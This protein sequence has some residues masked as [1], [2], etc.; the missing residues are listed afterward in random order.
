LVAAAIGCGSDSS[1]G[2][3]ETTTKE[4]LYPRIKG[5][6]REF[7][8]PGGDNVT[9]FFGT[10]ATATERENA[11]KVVHVWMK[12]RVAE[13]WP[14]DC[15]Y[16]ASEYKKSLVNDAYLVSERKVKTCPQA[17]EFFGDD[18]SGKTGNTL[19]GP[20][21]SLRIR[22]TITGK[23]EKE[24]FAQYHGRNGIDW[25]LPMRREN[26]EWKVSSASPVERTK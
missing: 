14:A 21:D 7:I 22:N 11:S 20:I 2:S 16:L 5:P 1:T 13:D 8:I 24:A 9:Q 18:A 15:S 17:L 4:V 26:G 3:S 25:L 12:A 19:T 10:E 6:G 23:S